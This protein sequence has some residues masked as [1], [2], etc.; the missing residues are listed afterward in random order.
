MN[1]LLEY[2]GFHAKIEF[3]AD[4]GMLFGTILG[5]DDCITFEGESTDEIRTAFHEAVEDYVEMCNK[6]GKI[7]MKH[8]KG[9]FNVRVSPDVH[10]SADLAA[11]RA[12]ISLNQF[13][14]RA[15]FASLG[16]KQKQ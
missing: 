6:V 7:P 10:K 8:Y 5:I 9:S 13:V 11:K 2:Q 12:G 14:E 4:D 1:H 15:I 16:L 3:N